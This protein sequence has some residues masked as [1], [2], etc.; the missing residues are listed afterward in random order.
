MSIK[1]N[2]REKQYL[3]KGISMKRS[4]VRRMM[5]ICRPLHLGQ[6]PAGFFLAAGLILLFQFARPAKA[7]T[8]SGYSEN[9]YFRIDWEYDLTAGTGILSLS[10]DH[11]EDYVNLDTFRFF[12]L[13]MTFTGITDRNG[14][15]Q[16]AD[17]SLTG[18]ID[19]KSLYQYDL[20]ANNSID[21]FGNSNRTPAKI[22]DLTFAPQSAELYAT[23]VNCAGLLSGF[24]G[25]LS[26]ANAVLM[27]TEMEFVSIQSIPEPATLVTL[28][29]G[30]AMAAAS[31]K[32]KEDSEE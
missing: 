14:I 32:R 29:V 26:G 2:W 25:L 13:G 12:T 17:P 22:F 19:G 30:A 8:A 1:N 11:P 23:Q 4:A 5:R 7:V 31:L 18:Q 6:V 10:T 24:A 16:F 9:D 20:K 15:T 21:I 3:G 27:S 28:G